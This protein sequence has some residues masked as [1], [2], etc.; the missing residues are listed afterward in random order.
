MIYEKNCT[1]YEI[2]KAN[3]I[4]YDYNFSKKQREVK[5]KIYDHVCD[6][7]A[8]DLYSDYFDDTDFLDFYDPVNNIH[9]CISKKSI[10]KFSLTEIEEID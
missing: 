5:E 8:S 9:H 2:F 3:V 10:I 1:V 4:F 6:P 7:F